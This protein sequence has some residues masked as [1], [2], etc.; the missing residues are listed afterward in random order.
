MSGL[1]FVGSPNTKL[2]CLRHG[3][4]GSG[5][6]EHRPL[7]LLS[8]PTHSQAINHHFPC[9]LL[10][11]SASGRPWAR[12]GS[13]PHS[14]PDSSGFHHAGLFILL[15][16]PQALSYL[17][18]FALAVPCAWILLHADNLVAPPSPLPGLYSKATFSASPYFKLHTQNFP[19]YLC[20]IC[21][22]GCLPTLL[23]HPHGKQ[24]YWFHPPMWIRTA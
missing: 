1:E 24:F 8:S 20:F 9:P 7:S 10:I 18:A 5:A 19:P 16:T 21:P 22:S 11:F 2:V 12:L 15:Q 3:N 4:D 6:S 14:L 23:W 17:R 13:C